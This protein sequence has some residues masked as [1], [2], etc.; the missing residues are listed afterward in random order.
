[1]ITY[2][3]TFLAVAVTAAQEAFQL[4]AP[5]ARWL[6]LDYVFLGQYSD[7]G[8]TAD[9]MLS[10]AIITGYTTPSAAGSAVTPKPLDPRRP[11]ATA[12]MRVNDTTLAVTGTALVRW[13]ETFR[14]MEGWRYNRDN[15]LDWS[16]PEIRRILVSPAE[17]LVVRI[18]APADS[19]T[20]NGTLVFTEYE[21]HDQF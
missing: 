6:S 1:M 20:M 12:T 13:S 7:F 8:D 11:A 2:T 18:T 3:A 15:G 9:E 19:I 21:P 5:A 10:V 4:V 14:I 17:Q 16:R